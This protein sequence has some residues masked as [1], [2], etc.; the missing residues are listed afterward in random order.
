MRISYWSSDVALPIFDPIDGTANFV[1]GL[2]WWC[3][4]I[5]LVVHDRLEL[6]LIYEPIAD[7]IYTARR[8]HGAFCNGQPIA[9]RSTSRLDSACRGLGTGTDEA[10]GPYT[11]GKAWWRGKGWQ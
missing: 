10:A 5:A 6:G 2:P 7:K 4:A 11:T 9:V 1:R 3:V 8:G